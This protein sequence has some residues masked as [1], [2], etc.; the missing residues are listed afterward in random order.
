MHTEPINDTG[1]YASL[2]ICTHNALK[3]RMC[4][5]GFRLI[6]VFPFSPSIAYVSPQI[7][8]ASSRGFN[9][10]EALKMFENRHCLPGFFFTAVKTQPSLPFSLHGTLIVGSC[11][12]ADLMHSQ[13]FT[14]SAFVKRQ[15]QNW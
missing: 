7:G 1:L 15:D 12:V 11:L 4:R 14:A 10:I 6:C 9:R 13:D 5:K 2:H 8:L 3:R